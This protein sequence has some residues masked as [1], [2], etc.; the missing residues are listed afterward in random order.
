MSTEEKALP[1]SL[2]SDDK[3]RPWTMAP[4]LENEIKE[5]NETLQDMMQNTSGSR[6]AGGRGLS[7]LDHKPQ[8]FIEFEVSMHFYACEV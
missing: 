1:V 3:L 6:I 5:K 8:S 4:E 7:E 2:W